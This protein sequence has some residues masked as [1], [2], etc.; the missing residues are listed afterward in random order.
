MAAPVEA[1]PGLDEPDPVGPRGL[2][3]RGEEMCVGH[4][5]ASRGA[6]RPACP[7]LGDGDGA[8]SGEHP[9]AVRFEG[10]P[11]EGGGVRVLPRQQPGCRGD[12]RDLGP[13]AGEGLGE[14]AAHGAAA[15]HREALREPGKG[16]E[17]LAREGSARAQTLEGG[18]GGCCAG[19]QQ[20]R[21]GGQPPP[22]EA[23]GPVRVQDGESVQDA[24]ARLLEGLGRIVWL[25]RGDGGP[26]PCH[27]DVEAEPVAGC[28]DEG[29]GRHAPRVEALPAGPGRLHQRHPGTEPGCGL[30]PD[31][32]RGPAADHHQVE[33][34]HQCRPF[35]LSRSVPCP[36]MARAC[37][38][39]L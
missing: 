27:R 9:H 3:G 22:L 5:G 34:R 26:R 4:L 32:P 12:D 38:D 37:N 28:G 35:M 10:V 8:V 29:L 14:L 7:V 19:G 20:D 23:D 25:D 36:T 1:D 11:H 31:Q 13:E 24:H 6:Q 30:S 16:P 17:R 2:P 33:S 15:D 18:E 21:Q 39:G